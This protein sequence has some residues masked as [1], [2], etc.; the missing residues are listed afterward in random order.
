MLVAFYKDIL[1]LVTLIFENKAFLRSM[2][3][4]MVFSKHRKP[5][6]TI[7]NAVLMLNSLRSIGLLFIILSKMSFVID[8][9]VVFCLRNSLFPLL[10]M[11]AMHCML[12]VVA[13]NVIRL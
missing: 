7:L 5:A 4:Y 6:H 9:H 1:D 10:I 3:V 11:N 13:I 2:P 12:K 8:R